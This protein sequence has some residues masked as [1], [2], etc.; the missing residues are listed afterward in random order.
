MI[1]PQTKQ[2]SS[3]V[4]FSFMSGGDS[5]GEPKIV[6]TKKYSIHLTFP[7]FVILVSI[8]IH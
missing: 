5:A 3:G 2:K 8:I 1:L 6:V 7:I 4:V